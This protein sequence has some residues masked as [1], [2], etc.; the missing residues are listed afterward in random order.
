MKRR[1][2][3]QPPENRRDLR[4]GMLQVRPDRGIARSAP[5]GDWTLIYREFSWITCVVR[6]DKHIGLVKLV[7]IQ[8]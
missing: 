7:S 1:Q 4:N 8:R 3:R 5:A 2:V 6:A